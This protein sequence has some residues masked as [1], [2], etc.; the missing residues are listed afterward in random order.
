MLEACIRVIPA[1]QL[2]GHF[3]DTY[4][5]AIANIVASLELGLRTFDSSVSGLGGCPYATGASGNVATEDVVSLLHGLGYETGIDLPK[6]IQAGMY[7]SSALGR[8]TS[9]RVALA[10]P[11]N[12]SSISVD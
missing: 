7:I 2:A 5:M 1:S 8:E 10:L 9:S 11:S 6:L 4:G 12:C 3:H